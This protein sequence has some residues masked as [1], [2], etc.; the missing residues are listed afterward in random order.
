MR[1][2]SINSNSELQSI[3]TKGHCLQWQF[4]VLFIQECSWW[5]TYQME[6]SH[7]CQIITRSQTRHCVITL[8][9][10]L[11]CLF[12]CL[13]LF[14][15]PWYFS[16][17]KILTLFFFLFF[18]KNISGVLINISLCCIDILRVAFFYLR[19]TQCLSIYLCH[20]QILINI[21]E[22]SVIFKYIITF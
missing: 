8:F 6:C 4:N 20:L 18:E 16:F 10:L 22:F 9:V 21:L 1:K 13:R 11:G 19:D 17:T 3:D 12:I 14:G 15:Y 2:K 5:A 7:H